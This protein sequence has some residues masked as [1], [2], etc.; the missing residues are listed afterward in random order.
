LVL[1]VACAG[2]NTIRGVGKDVTTVGGWVVK[3]ADNVE[4]PK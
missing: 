4:E 3:G 2:C 1:T